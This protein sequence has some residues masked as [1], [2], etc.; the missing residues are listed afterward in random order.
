MAEFSN[1]CTS[2]NHAFQVRNIKH[3]FCFVFYE[4]LFHT[5][6]HNNIFI[7]MKE[8]VKKQIVVVC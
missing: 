5:I 8:S 4:R 1:Y 3:E 2:L 6:L 7:V